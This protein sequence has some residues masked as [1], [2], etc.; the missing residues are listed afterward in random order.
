MKKK[1]VILGALVATASV[2]G[3]A[4]CTPKDNTT[5]STGATDTTTN[6]T[7]TAVD[8]TT[9]N[10]TTAVDTTTVATT[11]AN[12]TTDNTTTVATTTANTTTANT[13]T[14]ATTTANTTTDN[15][16][17]VATTTANTTTADTTTVNTTTVDTTTDTTTSTTDAQEAGETTVEVKFHYNPDNYDLVG[18]TVD[19]ELVKDAFGDLTSEFDIEQYKPTDSYRKFVGWYTDKELKTPFD[20]S[21]TLLEDVDLYAKWAG[22][23]INVTYELNAAKATSGSLAADYKSGIYTVSAGT[24]VR[25]N[26][27]DNTGA[28]HNSFKLGGTANIIKVEVPKDTTMTI[29][30]ADQSST[31]DAYLILCS[32][33]DCTNIVT[34]DIG[35]DGDTASSNGKLVNVPVKAGTYYIARGAGTVDVFTISLACNVDLA[36]AESIEMVSL[37]ENWVIEGNDYDPTDIKFKLN[38][39]NGSSEEIALNAKGVNINTSNVDVTTPGI[40]EVTVSYE[41]E[42][43]IY[44]EKLVNTY[45]TKYNVEVEELT[46]IVANTNVYTTGKTSYGTGTYINKTAP[47]VYLV[48]D[49]INT[50]YLIITAVTNTSTGE[51]THILATSQY[52]SDAE[53]TFDS[54]NAGVKTVTF[55]YT[56]NG[57]TETA[58]YTSTVTA[59]TPAYDAETNTINISVD[60]SY[61]G[62]IAAQTEIGSITANKFN[63]INAAMDFLHLYMDATDSKYAGCNINFMIAA[64]YYNEKVEFD[65]PNMTVTGAGRANVAATTTAGADVAKANYDFKSTTTATVIEFDAEYDMKDAAGHVHTTDSTA[66]VSVREAAENFKISGVS[67][68]NYINTIGKT[69]KN[70]EHRALAILVQADKFIMD[71]CDLYGYQDTIELYK[72]RQVI[73]NSLITGTTDFIF[74]ANNTTYFANCE[75]RTIQAEDSSGKVTESGGYITAFKGCSSGAADAVEYGAIFDG[76][77]FTC[78]AGVLKK[79]DTNKEGEIATT[80]NTAIARPWGLYA[81]VAVINSH[82]GGHISTASAATKDAEGK[83]GAAI[84]QNARY[85]KMSS[86]EPTASTLKF[87]EFNNDGDGAVDATEAANIAG[88]TFLTSDDAAKYSDM[89]VIFATPNGKVTYDDSWL[90]TLAKDTTITVATPDDTVLTTTLSYKN[91]TLTEDEIEEIIAS[92]K[93]EDGQEVKGLYTD[94]TFETEWDGKVGASDLTIYAKIA[95]AAET[96]T[97]SY[98]YGG[99]ND[100]AWVET[101]NATASSK[102]ATPVTGGKVASGDETDNLTVTIAATKKIE[103]A[104]TGFTTGSD[105]ASAFLGIKFYNGSTLVASSTGTTPLSKCNG[106]MT[107]ENDGVFEFETEITKIVFYSNTPNKTVGIVAVNVVA[108]KENDPNLIKANA[109]LTFGTSNT[110][111]DASAFQ[112]TTGQFV[113]NGVTLNIDATASTGKFD[114]TNN[115]NY[116]Q[117]NAGTIITFKVLA[118]AKITIAAYSANSLTVALGSATAVANATNPQEYTATEDCTVTITYTANDWLGAITVQYN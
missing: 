91:I 107:L 32:D 39:Q 117:C 77:N 111:A 30:M 96:V 89:K 84:S 57:K 80:G 74:G 6:N 43:T 56:T 15:T 109:S 52:T 67:I 8:T 97:Y 85:V 47:Q 51:K 11:T 2:V 59:A 49:S 70:G 22:D 17:T 27:K 78:D 4:A 72:G 18:N 118:G 62:E 10:T 66:T 13:T 34:N 76:C 58:T 64:G 40:Y 102:D 23:S 115:A 54:A 25:T 68:S 94:A 41:L 88:L 99:T 29:D 92:I 108:Y 105:K 48:G 95:A 45:T 69:Y 114:N 35:K 113:V 33:A 73:Q 110:K 98:K 101:Y 112:G 24:E 5:G 16:T 7:T 100:A 93:V 9:A 104:V 38:Y 3:L 103:L 65:L 46:E 82:L 21:E 28:V 36:P 87:A 60:A 83:W 50:T 79:G 37:G 12:T 20:A 75:I 42:E 81:K 116:A 31:T 90:G 86:N 26:K 55:T 71:D 1:K 14:V 19:V 63:T 53:T 106:A 44:N 61:G